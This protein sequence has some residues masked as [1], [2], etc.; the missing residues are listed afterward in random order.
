[1]KIDAYTMLDREIAIMKKVDHQNIVK[2]FEVFKNWLINPIK[3]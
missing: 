1:M 3:R 2:L